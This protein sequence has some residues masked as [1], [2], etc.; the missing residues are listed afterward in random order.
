MGGAVIKDVIRA[1]DV[2]NLSLIPS[3][4]RLASADVELSG[5]LYAI[6]DKLEEVADDYDVVVIDCSPSL[7]TVT[8][9]ALNAADYAIIPVQTEPHSVVGLTR[10]MTTINQ[11]RRSANKKLEILGLVP[12]MHNARV[13]TCKDSLI[14]LYTKLGSKMR[15]F[16]PIPRSA[17]YLQATALNM[18][19]LVADKNAPGLSTYL[20]ISNAL[21]EKQNG[22][23]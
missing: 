5:Q 1:T 6:R 14:E 4:T 19:T 7:S 3:Y 8:L 20:E 18:I 13:G 21:M 15:I 23:V 12:T 11:I 16:T 22:T 2:Q 10:M 17:V 9:A